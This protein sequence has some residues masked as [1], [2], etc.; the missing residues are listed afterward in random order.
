LADEERLYQP[1]LPGQD[2]GRWTEEK[3]RLIAVYM[4]AVNAH[5]G[6]V[7]LLKAVRDQPEAFSSA[8]T[9]AKEAH[10]ECG[11]VKIPNW[12]NNCK[13]NGY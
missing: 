7:G 9:K 2:I 1:D 6:T 12:K 10:V 5:A 3:D 4:E 8:L 11:R 13:T